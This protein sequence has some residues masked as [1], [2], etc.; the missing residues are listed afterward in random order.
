MR[1]KKKITGK[2]VLKLPPKR[3]RQKMS[4]DARVPVFSAF[5]RKTRKNNVATFSFTSVSPEES[6]KRSKTSR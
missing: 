4:A 6:K 1:G 5:L 3:R 2:L